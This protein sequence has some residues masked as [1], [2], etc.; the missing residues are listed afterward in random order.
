MK[1]GWGSPLGT[2]PPAHGAAIGGGAL[3]EL[4]GDGGSGQSPMDV[5]GGAG[6]V[7]QLIVAGD[8][9]DFTGLQIGAGGEGPDHERGGVN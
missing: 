8:P 9:L 5:G 4:G 1:Q 6:T 2:D 7:L 3:S